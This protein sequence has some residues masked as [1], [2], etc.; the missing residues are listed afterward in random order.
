MFKTSL[1][2]L[3]IFACFIPLIFSQTTQPDQVIGFFRHGAR[4][5]LSG[6]DSTW[7]YDD[8]GML[9]ATGM[10]QEFL[11]GQVLAKKYSNIF[12]PAYDPFYILFLSDYTYRCIES[13]VAVADGVYYGNGPKLRTNQNQYVTV[14]PFN[15][16]S[17]SDIV[18]SIGG[19]SAVPG[20]RAPVIVDTVDSSSYKIFER[21]LSSSLCPMAET[22]VDQNNDDARTAAAWNIFKPTIDKVNKY[23]SSSNKLTTPYAVTIYGDFLL[24]NLADNRAIPGGLTDP[25]II[26]GFISAYSWFVFYQE[27]GQLV[28]RQVAAYYAVKEVLTQLN[29][30]MTDSYYLYNAALYG[31]HDYNIYAILAAFGIVTDDCLMSNFYSYQSTGT[32]LYPACVFPTFASNLI[33]ELYTENQ[34]TPYVR[35]L[36][37][38]IW[39]KLCQNNSRDC[40]YDEFVTFANN[41]IG[42][43]SS[44][45]FKSKCA[46]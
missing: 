12:G 37:N 3:F 18:N 46:V 21:F 24:V 40:N 1:I 33:F 35:V 19:T 30:Y 13:L 39:I 2:P 23:L 22:W 14:P 15:D 27:Y 28:Q 17:I 9:T 20:Q 42:N 11:M 41:A 10:R 8:W 31:A 36:Y 25:T 45:T 6:Y 29:Y 43:M 34:V 38:N 16:P 4:G 5:P 44:T 26:N 7:S 32:Y